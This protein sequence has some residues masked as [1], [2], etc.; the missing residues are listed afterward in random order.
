[1]IIIP[2]DRTD[3]AN[4]VPNR[5]AFGDV[6]SPKSSPAYATKWR[7]E[8]VLTHGGPKLA[9]TEARLYDLGVLRSV[10]E[11]VVEMAVADARADGVTWPRIGDALGATHQ[12][13]IKRYRKGGGR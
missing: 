6:P 2:S 12:A 4:L 8:H 3:S 13:V 9:D 11:E 5:C 10:L 1:M 7:A